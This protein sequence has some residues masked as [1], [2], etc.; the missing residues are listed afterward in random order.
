L[1]GEAGD[2][3]SISVVAAQ[4]PHVHSYGRHEEVKDG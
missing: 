4:N 1:G 3:D 2:L